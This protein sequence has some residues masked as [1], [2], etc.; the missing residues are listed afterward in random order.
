M[1]EK[2]ISALEKLPSFDLG[3]D[4]DIEVFGNLK[5]ADA[6]LGGTASDADEIEEIDEEEEELKKQAAKKKAEEDKKK[7]VKK[8]PDAAKL[9]ESFLGAE[10]EEE[11]E[12]GSEEGEETE[13]GSE[14]GTSDEN[15]FPS[16]AKELFKTNILTLDD[17]EEE[18]EISSPEELLQLFQHEKQKGATV[19]LENFLSQHGE[20]RREIF[21]AIFINGVEPKDYLSLYTSIENFENIDLTNETNQEKVVKSYYQ[22]SGMA[23]DKIAAKIEKLKSY[24]DLQEEAE[25][26]HP[27]IVEQDKDKLAEMEQE[28]KKEQAQK[29]AADRVYKENIQKTLQTAIKEKHIGG[30]PVNDKD[31]NK[32]FDFMYNKKWK[33]GNGETIT[34]LDKFVLESKKPENLK[35]RVMLSLLALS[36][37][38]FSKIEKK[39]ISKEA[40]SLFSS[41]AQK[42]AKK[43]NKMPVKGGNPWANL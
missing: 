3:M 13:E 17:G 40:G 33:L 30:I 14:E 12:E 29:A 25:T 7:T 35:N 8:A 41:L 36:N 9:A 23:D 22:R 31:A 42:T 20:D 27:L 16:L 11:E 28:K 15:V 38:D 18:P 5:D 10:E 2:D 4:G 26:V 39:A 43:S 21:D 37:F 24:G 19:W 32:V 1:A 6:F 34:D